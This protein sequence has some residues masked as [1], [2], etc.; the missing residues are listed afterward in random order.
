[1]G[2]ERTGKGHVM[3]LLCLPVP[4]RTS[5]RVKIREERYMD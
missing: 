1:M 4:D 5:V 2:A 3:A